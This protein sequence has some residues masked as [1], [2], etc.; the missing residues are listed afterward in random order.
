MRHYRDRDIV[1]FGKHYANHVNAMTKEGLH[2]K[3]DIAAELA[4]RDQLLS[5]CYKL[6]GDTVYF[7]ESL[8]S[9]S[10]DERE[11]AREHSEL[12]DKTYRLI[13]EIVEVE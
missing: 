9:L 8:D 2:E 6:L 3:S 1:Q 13:E 11:A 12:K 7:N 4:Y 10:Y 5:V